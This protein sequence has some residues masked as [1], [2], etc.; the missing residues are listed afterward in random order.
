MSKP[1]LD[2]PDQYLREIALKKA[3]GVALTPKDVRRLA[4]R[5]GVEA[6]TK[7]EGGTVQ[8]GPPSPNGVPNYGGQ[9]AQATAPAIEPAPT[10]VS[11]PSFQTPSAS[12]TPSS[13]E[14]PPA[15]Q[16]PAIAPLPGSFDPVPSF[17]NKLTFDT[18]FS[19][20]GWTGPGGKY[21]PAGVVHAGE[22]VIPKSEVERIGVDKLDAKYGTDSSVLKAGYDKGALVRLPASSATQADPTKF[23]TAHQYLK[24]KGYPEAQLN[25]LINTGRGNLLLQEA[26]L[27]QREDA[28]GIASQNWAEAERGLTAARSALDE[29]TNAKLDTASKKAVED[30]LGK[31]RLNKDPR[32]DA[33]VGKQIGEDPATGAPVM[34]PDRPAIARPE[35]LLTIGAR[36][37]LFNAVKV[38]VEP[39]KT[40]LEQTA[41]V[42]R[43]EWDKQ[44]M[45]FASADKALSSMGIA[46]PR[47]GAVYKPVNRFEGGGNAEARQN[48]LYQAREQK[49]NADYAIANRP[50]A[51]Q[52]SEQA[53]R[54]GTSPMIR[55]DAGSVEFGRGGLPLGSTGY[56]AADGSYKVIGTD[57]KTQS[58]ANE[59]EATTKLATVYGP[60]QP[61]MA[62][63][64]SQETIDR[65]NA[66][67]DA[68]DA[69]IEAARRAAVPAPVTLQ[70][71][72]QYEQ[73]PDVVEAQNAVALTGG[74]P[75]SQ[76]TIDEYRRRAVAAQGLVPSAFSPEITAEEAR[77]RLRNVFTV[78]QAL[79]AQVA[80]RGIDPTQ[81]DRF[82]AMPADLMEQAARLPEGSAA[83]NALEARVAAIR[84]GLERRVAKPLAPVAAPDESASNVFFA[85]AQ[86]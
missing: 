34:S 59:Q 11:A 10:L 13:Y 80:I 75:P 8:V 62:A 38:V 19:S 70:A 69:A 17:G 12:F 39:I 21:E 44:N 4:Q 42:A 64:V 83:R 71:P 2:A 43:A 79:G 50:L 63:G 61:A 35:D 74:L 68:R 56:Q 51:A 47:D 16:A 28:K 26:A 77:G 24:S 25:T 84:A 86:A 22:F 48:A 72:P 46:P 67:G 20:G 3:N 37:P 65:M 52:L 31:L 1:I 9:P 78:P 18:K 45:R 40:G 30:L 27:M 7:A 58:F 55:V 36:D 54:T 82:S 49:L 29:A 32:L 76:A 23:Y 85:G 57:G 5:Q 66:E 6:Q 73:F 33:Q 14:L 60:E 81:P 15:F 41:R 53:L